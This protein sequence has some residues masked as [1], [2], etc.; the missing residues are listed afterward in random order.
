MAN[1]VKYNLSA[2]TLALK[3][4]D[5]YIG[6]GD[7]GKGLTYY[8]GFDPPA[9]GYTI[10][11]NKAS[12]GPSVY[13]VSSNPQLIS[14]TNTI[15][16]QTFTTAESALDWYNSQTDKMVINV[17]YPS[18][19]TDGLVLNLAAG[20]TPSY[21]TTGTTWYDLSASGANATIVGS[22]VF[23]T[24]V[25]DFGGSFFCEYGQYFNLSTSSIFTNSSYTIETWQEVNSFPIPQRNAFRTSVSING[26]EA[27]NL[28]SIEWYTTGSNFVSVVNANQSEIAS[29]AGAYSLNTWCQVVFTYDYSNNTGILYIN[30]VQNAS[31]AFAPFVGNSPTIRL[32]REVPGCVNCFNWGGNFA[33]NR[34]YNRSL[35]AAEVLQ[36]YNAE[37]A[38]QNLLSAEYQA[39]LNY[40]TSLGYTLPSTDQRL[41]Q[42]KL[43]V[44]LKRAG[45]WEKLDTFA[46]FAT[47][48]DSNF[49]LIDWKRLTTYTAWN[50]PPF[51]TNAGFKGTGTTSYIDTNFNPATGGVNYTLNNASRFMWIKITAGSGRYIDGNAV[52]S[53][54]GMFS[55]NP[56]P[57]H[58]INQGTVNSSAS[59]SLNSVG[60][61]SIHRTSSTNVELF[62]N[63]SQVSAQ[64]TSTAISS[65]NQLILRGGSSY[66]NH[67]ASAYGMGASLVSEN[68]AL[69]NALNTYI[70]SL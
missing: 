34:F 31:G 42:D 23:S 60:L 13:A 1:P 54:N 7:V 11:L 21:P 25:N 38:Q 32:G 14:L 66:S 26:Q 16:G 70:T 55:T 5:F 62:S 15:S 40:A 33:I 65:N 3:K 17:N 46:V 58:K 27:G 43:L 64:A 57:N 6:T 61:S 63:L 59:A 41:K 67:Q 68:T 50:T 22:P 24:G 39:I 52:N 4:G 20:F 2:E 8:S 45:V 35:S 47:D 53:T 12:G 28:I 36:N 56:T 69:Y 48:G 19:V 51:T 9:G 30:G 37:I 18:I 29:T 44:D 10:Y 49:A